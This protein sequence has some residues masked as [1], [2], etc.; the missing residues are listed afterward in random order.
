MLH[1]AFNNTFELFFFL[2]FFLEQE[3]C[4]QVRFYEDFLISWVQNKLMLLD[5][6]VDPHFEQMSLNRLQRNPQ[7][8]ILL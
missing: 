8:N 3:L 4:I 6:Y 7:N 2:W 5:I 1:V